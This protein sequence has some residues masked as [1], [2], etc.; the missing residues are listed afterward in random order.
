[1]GVIA[2]HTVFG[3][4]LEEIGGNGIQSL[5]HDLLS[6]YGSKVSL[7]SCKS[8]RRGGIYLSFVISIKCF[9]DALVYFVQYVWL[10]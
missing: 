2:F 7:C 10:L 5:P 9:S 3:R 4:L 6:Y 8:N 1:M